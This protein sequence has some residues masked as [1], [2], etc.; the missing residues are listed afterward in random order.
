MQAERRD[1]NERDIIDAMTAIGAYVRQMKAGAGFDLLVFYQGL[2]FVMEVKQ[3]GKHLTQHEI[4]T[5]SRIERA[6][7]VYHVVYTAVQALE[8]LRGGVKMEVKTLSFYE[9]Q[10]KLKF[11]ED[12]IGRLKARIAELEYILAIERDA[13]TCAAL[14]SVADGE[15]LD[16]D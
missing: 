12:E 1:I 7:G 5:A 14:D 10:Q 8:I 6:G 2:I 9:I 16:G 3:F 13:E 11:A 4:L 15:V